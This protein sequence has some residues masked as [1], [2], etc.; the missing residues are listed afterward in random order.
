M[1]EIHDQIDVIE[2]CLWN[3]QK[4][5]GLDLIHAHANEGRRTK[6]QNGMLKAAGMRKGFPDLELPAPLAPSLFIEMKSKKGRVRPEQEVWR[7][8]IIEAGHVHHVCFNSYEATDAIEAYY[9]EYWPDAI[10]L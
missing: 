4:Y 9:R 10:L 2:W 1:A 6:V 5:K 8:R 3:R 7:Q